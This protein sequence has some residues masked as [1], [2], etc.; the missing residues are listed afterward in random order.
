M[1]QFT[2]GCL[3]GSVRLTSTGQPDRVGICHCLDCRK[4]HGA[5]F[6]ASAIFPREAVTVIGEIH[7]HIRSDISSRAVA[8][9]SSHASWM[10]S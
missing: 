2:G 5:L 8:P 3:C 6:L 1:T 9:R 7:A 4:H 10:R